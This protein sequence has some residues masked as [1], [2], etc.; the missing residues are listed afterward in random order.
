MK[1]EIL[2]VL[3]TVQND[4]DVLECLNALLCGSKPDTTVGDALLTASM[5]VD[6]YITYDRDEK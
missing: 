1:N 5:A 2:A 6:G 3:R 4:E